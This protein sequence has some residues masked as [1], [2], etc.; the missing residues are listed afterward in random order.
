LK[1]SG[2]AQQR[3]IFGLAAA[4]LIRFRQYTVPLAVLIVAVLGTGAVS[5]RLLRLDSL[6]N[7]LTDAC[8]L[9]ILVIGATLP[10]LLGSIDLSLA[11]MASFSSVLSVRIYPELGSW[12][13]PVVV[14]ICASIGAGQGFFQAWVQIPSLVVTLGMLGILEGAAMLLTNGTPEPVPESDVVIHFVSGTTWGV[15]NSALVVLAVL[16]LLGGLM[17]Y[18][19]LGRDIFACGSGERAAA[20]SGVNTLRIR[21]IAFS[22]SAACGAL[23]GMLLLSITTFSSP[24]LAGNFLLLSIVG[25]LIGGAAISG[26]VGGLLSGV[27]GGLMASWFSIAT[28]VI[29]ISAEAQNAVFGIMALVAGALTTDRSKIGIIK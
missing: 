26:G 1:K 3:N 23:G 24:N 14:L 10:I 22:I 13:T 28:V 8:P 9:L 25:V 11:G 21:I 5:P 19:R 18:T 12:S 4:W 20:L 16:A 15:P 17:R 2:L 6:M 7:F 29:G 27:I